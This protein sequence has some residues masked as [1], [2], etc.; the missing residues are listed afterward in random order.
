MHSKEMQSPKLRAIECV[1][2]EQIRA[3][4]S[5]EVSECN[6][7]YLAPFA[8]GR[9]AWLGK[10]LAGA[11]PAL[12][13][14]HLCHLFILLLGLSL[15]TRT[16]LPLQLGTSTSAL[17]P[18]VLLSIQFLTTPAQPT[19]CLPTIPSLL[20]SAPNS[21]HGQAAAALWFL[22]RGRPFLRGQWYVRRR[23]RAPGVSLRMR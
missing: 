21:K 13:A 8:P 14:G 2:N 22:V 12:A 11:P 23:A 4:A 9:T 20:S 3:R 15:E 18:A 10:H 16:P 1:S 19:V 5:E 7:R 17:R 6:S